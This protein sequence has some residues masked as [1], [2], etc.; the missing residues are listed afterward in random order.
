MKVLDQRE[1]LDALGATV[2]FVVHDEP[3]RVRRGLLDGLHVPF[4]VLVDT[5]RIAYRAWGL[6]RWQGSGWT[7]AS[8]FAMPCC[9]HEASG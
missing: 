8:G 4:P 5:Q 3:E 7:R 1:K 9:S 6:R 2:L